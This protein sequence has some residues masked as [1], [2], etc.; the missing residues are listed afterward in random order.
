VAGRPPWGAEALP[1]PLWRAAL[2]CRC[3]RC[4]EASIYAGILAVRER[5]PVCGLDLSRADVGDGLAVPLVLVLGFLIVGLAFWVE[6]RF[7]PPLWVHAVLW[8]AIT[9]PLAILLMRPLK[10]FL[11]A[12]QFHRRPEE[13]GV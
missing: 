2:L 7:S 10:A 12:Q 5:C 4:G 11:V 3:P 1:T 6:F 8:P 9:I 13:M